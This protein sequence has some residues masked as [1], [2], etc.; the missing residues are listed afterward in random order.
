MKRLMLT[1]VVAFATMAI[2]GI[3]STPAPTASDV[4]IKD[5]VGVE[6]LIALDTTQETDT[7]AM[8]GLSVYGDRAARPYDGVVGYIYANTPDSIEGVTGD[9]MGLSDTVIVTVCVKFGDYRVDTIKVDTLLTPDTMHFEWWGDYEHNPTGENVVMSVAD[10]VGG[11]VYVPGQ[12]TAQFLLYDDL[13]FIATAYDSTTE[14]D[15]VHWR[16]DYRVRLIER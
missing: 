5:T 12:A 13:F 10:S 8:I 4:K 14:E 3:V 7:S 15:T 6:T 11:G 2:V 9:S 1:V 16:L